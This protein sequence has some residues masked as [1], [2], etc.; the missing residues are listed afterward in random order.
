MSFFSSEI[1]KLLRGV[2]SRQ[3]IPDDKAIEE[4][5]NWVASQ[6][7]VETHVHLEAAVGASFYLERMNS[8]ELNSPPPWKR[9]PFADLRDFI[10]AWVDLSRCVR[11]ESDFEKMVMMFVQGRAQQR[12]LYTECYIS[13]ADYS[14]MR[15]RFAIAPEVFDFANVLK[16]YVRG[17]KAA[18]KR[19]PGCEVRFV[20]DALW[21]SN[22]E[23]R[24]QILQTLEMS[25]KDSDFFDEQGKP[26]IV[27][28]GLGGA[29]SHHDIDGH[30]E[31][32]SSVRSLG[33]KVDIHSGEGGDL[34]IHRKTLEEINPDRVAHGFAGFSDGFYFSKNIVMCPLSN[35][36]LSTFKGKPEE[37]P[38]FQLLKSGAPF[39]LGT[40]DPLLLGHTLAQEFA[41]LFAVA[42][43]L[44]KSMFYKI[45]RNTLQSVLAPEICARVFPSES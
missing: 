30:R 3:V 23:E 31:F 19:F 21:P 12:I 20:V 41:F 18:L 28:I 4:F 2:G 8:S 13:P 16:A 14:F 17:L 25:T 24:E 27:A 34:T 42:G 39:A 29:E 40:D 1:E 36:L 5:H 10:R 38:V 11:S 15:R 9:A 22:R 45:R 35:L 33:F 43:A 44:D 32:M 6:E 37:H 26:Y 7:M